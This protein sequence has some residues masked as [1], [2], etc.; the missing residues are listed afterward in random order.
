MDYTILKWQRLN[1]YPDVMILSLV[2]C[3]AFPIFIELLKYSY[4][5]KLKNHFVLL[6]FAARWADNNSD[7]PMIMVFDLEIGH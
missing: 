3:T 7:T 2:I 5:A 6:I 4:Q 1:W